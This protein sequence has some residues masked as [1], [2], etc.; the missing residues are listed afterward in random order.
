MPRL[1]VGSPATSSAWRFRW[2]R[3]A[4]E[5]LL[6][7]VVLLLADVGDKFR[8]RK[9][10]GWAVEFQGDERLALG[11]QQYRHT[12]GAV[13]RV[14]GQCRSVSADLGRFRYRVFDS[15]GLRALRRV[16]GVRR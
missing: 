2:T 5:P 3:S 9:R 15:A 10:V 8:R 4:A 1:S 16:Q 11:E 6:D 7:R 14:P 13:R 12:V